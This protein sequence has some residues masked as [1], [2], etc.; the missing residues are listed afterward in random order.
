MKITNLRHVSQDYYSNRLVV[1]NVT[2]T[3]SL[4]SV[5]ISKNKIYKIK[6]FNFINYSFFS[7][8]SL[9]S[10][11]NVALLICNDDD[12]LNNIYLG[13]LATFGAPVSFVY[14]DASGTSFNYEF[15]KISSMD[16]EPT[17]SRNFQASNFNVIQTQHLQNQ[18][19]YQVFEQ[20]NCFSG[21]LRIVPVTT[22]VTTNA[23]TNLIYSNY[24][25]DFTFYNNLSSKLNILCY[26]TDLPN[27]NDFY[28][29]Y[30]TVDFDLEEFEE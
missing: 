8:P 13:Y 12:F 6:N 10:E 20:I 5:N 16:I 11:V 14:K 4:K 29:L 18:N 9:N 28:T 26:F 17:T 19:L 30:G 23:G 1:G 3:L 27:T 7:N 22:N 25:T 21:L 15:P 24:S 2:E